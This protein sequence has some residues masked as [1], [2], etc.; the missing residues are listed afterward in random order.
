MTKNLKNLEIKL[1]VKFKKPELLAQALI[2]RSYLNETTGRG[3]NS[4]E[5]LEFLGD[6]ILELVISEWPFS[7]FP[8][9]PEGILTNLRSNIVRTTALARIAQELA[10]GEHILLSKGERNSH[11]SEN[12]SILADTLEAIIGAIYLDQGNKAA[13]KFIREKFRSLIKEVSQKSQYKDAKSLLQEKLQAESKETPVYKTLKEEGPD[14]DKSFTLGV[15]A[16]GRL[17]AKGTGK[18]KQ[19]AEEAAAQKALKND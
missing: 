6:A 1:G 19:L 17:L 8:Q 4:N 5:R 7:Q 15:Y 2:H 12:P 16:N 18:S 13:K 9:Y 14:H 3:L 11:G 10:V